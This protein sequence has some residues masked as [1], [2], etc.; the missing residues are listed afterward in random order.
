MQYYLSESE[1][2]FYK[3]M[4]PK[5]KA[6]FKYIKAGKKNTNVDLL[7]HISDY[8]ECSVKEAN[9]YRDILRGKDLKHILTQMGVD[10][11]EQKLILKQ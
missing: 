10:E 3:E 4:L 11:K 1:Y 6:F 9:E 7:K 2:N 5:S 8:F